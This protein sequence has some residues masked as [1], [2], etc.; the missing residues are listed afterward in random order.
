MACDKKYKFFVTLVVFVFGYNEMV[1]C[2]PEPAA[3]SDEVS[4]SLA[5]MSNN[6]DGG[7]IQE[8]SLENVN[9]EINTYIEADESDVGKEKRYCK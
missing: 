7:N 4:I 5:I 6:G 1:W 3:A 2:M 9:V 8:S